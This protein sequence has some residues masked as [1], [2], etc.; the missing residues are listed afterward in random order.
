[1]SRTRSMP[2]ASTRSV[3][4]TSSP[5][6]RKAAVRAAPSP[7]AAPVTRTRLVGIRVLAQ[8]DLGD[9]VAV[10]LV[11]PVGQPQRARSDV[12]PGEREVLGHAGAAVQLDGHVDHVERHVGHLDLDLA[13]GRDRLHRQALV[14]QPG[15]VHDEQ[16]R[17][18][19]GDAGV[20]DALAVAAEVGQRLAEGGPPGRARRRRAR[21]PSRRAR[22]RACSGGRDRGRGGPGRSRTRDPRR[23]GCWRR[24]RARCRRTP[25]RGRAARRSS[26][27]C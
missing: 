8:L 6:A 13:D 2:S 24:A 4:S 9:H 14:E 10:H 26:P 5:R 19:D 23:A 1:M 27:S 16:A 21:A 25:R 22:W 7:E 15:G 12:R 17:A 11:G 18:V 3:A 20:G